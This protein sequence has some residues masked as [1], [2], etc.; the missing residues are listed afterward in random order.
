MSQPAFPESS[1]NRAL[2]Q[3]HYQAKERTDGKH[4]KFEN[5]NIDEI[6]CYPAP[7]WSRK[8]KRL[9]IARNKFLE[10]AQELVTCVQCENT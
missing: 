7:S 4:E 9:L 5:Q 6:L 8:D 10:G 1:V 3:H 2:S